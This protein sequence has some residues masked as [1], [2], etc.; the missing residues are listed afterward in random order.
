MKRVS[1]KHLA[2][3]LE[4]KGWTHTRTRGSHRRYSKPGFPPVTV[5]VHGNKTL[6]PRT[7]Q[8]IMRSAGLSDA[9]L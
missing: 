6:K 1:G 3:V 5:L 7:Q 4:K 9:D 8:N 2:G